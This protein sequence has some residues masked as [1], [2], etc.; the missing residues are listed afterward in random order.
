MVTVGYSVISKNEVR[1]QFWKIEYLKKEIARSQES[2]HPPA[3][4]KKV[5]GLYSEL[6]I[7]YGPLSIS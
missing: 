4:A 7:L 2:N 1:T 6:L 5:D 3:I